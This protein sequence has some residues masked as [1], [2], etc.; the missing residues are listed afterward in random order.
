ME[1]SHIADGNIKSLVISQKVPY[2][3]AV[4]LLGVHSGEMKKHIPT[5][6]PISECSQQH[7]LQ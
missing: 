6:R 2:D 3:S 1:C 5:Q 4:L 7:Y